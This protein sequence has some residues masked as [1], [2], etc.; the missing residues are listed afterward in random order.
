[1]N[2]GL[3]FFQSTGHDSGSLRGRGTHETPA[4]SSD[5]EHSMREARLAQRSWRSA[6]VATRLDI[7]KRARHLLADRLE[8]SVGVTRTDLGSRAD[9]LMAEV[10]PLL[11]AI[12]FLE[13]EAPRLLAKRS[14]GR[15]GRPVWLGGVDL[16][17]HRDPLGLVLIIGAFNYPLFL[18]GVQCF[19]ALAAGNAVVVKPGAGGRAAA[20]LLRETLIEA[21]LDQDLLVVLSEAT[22]DAQKAIA[23]GV[24]RVLLTG[25]RSTGRAVLEQLVEPIVPATLELSGN[26]AVFVLEGADLDRVVR[27][28][29]FGVTLNESSTCIAPRRVFVASSLAS[30]LRNRL[31]E[32]FRE[33][34]PLRIGARA[35]ELAL[36][37]VEEARRAGAT[38]EL[39]PRGGEE[40]LAPVL[41]S[42]VKADMEITRTDLFAPLLSLLEFE[43]PTESTALRA[44]ASCPCQLGASVFGPPGEAREFAER[45][46]AGVV[47]VNDLILPTADPRVPFG[48]RKES[49]FGV[50]R[51][52]EGL[53]ELTA[54]RA[55][56]VRTSS[57]L[58]HLE[59]RRPGDSRLLFALA[60]WVHGGGFRSRL[61]ALL[62]LLRSLAGRPGQDGP[63]VKK[64]ESENP[65]R[66]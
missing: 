29:V 60:R 37:L 18:V 56:C 31:L 43:I 40:H 13:R 3:T 2:E 22:A 49:G 59:S 10:F 45:L 11:D 38:V 6:S 55:I 24:D 25:S 8:R 28:L 63:T 51:G 19:Q 7:L 48:G 39:E 53:L 27:A 66:E 20:E 12:Q 50:T 9:R 21:G 46:E 5:I 33:L 61:R 65:N 15:R 36:E 62:E 16:E 58:R 34:P 52:A 26:D 41:L 64:T 54:P 35:R 23:A 32:V 1:M 42:K 14:N 17:I 57:R 30:T 4:T 47:V 44:Y